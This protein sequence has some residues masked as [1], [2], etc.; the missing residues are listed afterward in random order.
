MGGQNCLWNMLPKEMCSTIFSFMD[1]EELSS[2]SRVCKEW[3]L[4][5]WG[6]VRKISIG[7]NESHRLSCLTK[8]ARIRTLDLSWQKEEEIPKWQESVSKL[9][10]LRKLCFYHRVES[11]RPHD[12]QLLSTL[13]NLECLSLIYLRRPIGVS[14][15][16]LRNMKKL[17]KL[18]VGY[19][20]R[21]SGS[22]EPVT[23]IT[24]LEKLFLNGADI[25]DSGAQ[26]LTSLKRL[27][28]L[29]L[30]CNSTISDNGLQNYTRLTC[31]Q[32]LRSAEELR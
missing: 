16:F 18:C 22:L 32:K 26:T 25:H 6:L 20:I 5:I 8:M 3:N 17:R 7:N 27:N 23:S 13:T 29:D 12:F 9:T 2:A 24:T 1:M 30:S 21:I 4:I 10:A 31:L 15:E 19:S 28:T 14:V 11:P